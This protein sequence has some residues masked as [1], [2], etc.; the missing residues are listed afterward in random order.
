M[1]TFLGKKSATA[2]VIFEVIVIGFSIDRNLS[3]WIFE[4]C[5]KTDTTFLLLLLFSMNVQVKPISRNSEG[6]KL[7]QENPDY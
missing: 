6:A 7:G 1:W 2:E 5:D 4:K 3:V